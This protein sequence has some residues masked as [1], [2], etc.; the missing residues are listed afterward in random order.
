MK[1]FITA[2][3][4]CVVPA[5]AAPACT[6]ATY[7]TYVSLA[8]GCSIGDA[9][10]SNFSGFGFVNSAGVPV[11]PENQVL[12][13]PTET[14]G[15]VALM[16]T[17]LNAN[18][19]PT[20]VTVSS[21]GEIFSFG[22]FFQVVVNPSTLSGFQMDAAFA[23]TQPGSVS[24]TKTVQP[25]GGGPTVT[26]TVSD[27]GASN[28]LGEYDG[29]TAVITGHGPFL[30]A[31]TNSLQAQL[32]GI[33]TEAS[34]TNIFDLQT[35]STTTPELKSFAMI[36]SGLVFLSLVASSTRKRQKFNS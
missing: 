12:V 1:T 13:T 36:G 5:M 23:N 10:F 22:F 4:I 28:P 9:T 30:V 25:V 27:D 34:F 31:D 26:S 16:F 14:N 2:L 32:N 7:D 6:T 21:F 20:P 11:L 24:S 15:N 29:A 8:G 19:T 18:G 17:Y 35:G 33:A 3:C